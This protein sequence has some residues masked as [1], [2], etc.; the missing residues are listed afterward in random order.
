[1]I[2]Q[3]HSLLPAAEAGHTLFQ[4]DFQDGLRHTGDDAPWELRPAG[5]FPHGDGIV[6]RTPDGFA[7]VPT[8]LHPATGEPAFARPTGPEP[9]SALLRWTAALRAT[10]SSGAPG[11]DAE[12][13]RLLTAE[14]ELA[15]RAFGTGGSPADGTAAD[16]ARDVARAAGVLLAFD[17]ETGMVFDF[18]LTGSAVYAIYER[19]P[20]A[21]RTHRAFSCA[22]PLAG[23]RP[24]RFHHCAL[25]LDRTASTVTWTLDGS[26]VLSVASIGYQDFHDSFLMWDVP[27]AEEAVTP[28]QLDFGFSLFAAE[29]AG[30]GIRLESR[31]LRVTTQP[32]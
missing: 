17:R 9:P 13:G 28:R 25:T 12:P 7:V 6:H 23:V 8:D 1:M 16:P 30:Q 29:P 18:A 14:A 24:G 21:G 15:V 32:V 3:Q 26:E 22:V 20:V 27:G 31:G 11:F 4:D 2:T 10:A 5:G 19:L